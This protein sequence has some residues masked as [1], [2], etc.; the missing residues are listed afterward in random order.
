MRIL[1]IFLNLIWRER[2]I[3]DQVCQSDIDSKN[4]HVLIFLFIIYPV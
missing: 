3:F 1:H 2:D 4:N